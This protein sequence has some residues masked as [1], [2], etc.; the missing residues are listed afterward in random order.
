[1]GEIIYRL[2]KVKYNNKVMQNI[3]GMAQLL[4]T[5]CVPATQHSNLT[6][7]SPTLDSTKI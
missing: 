6:N 4:K 2:S 3:R 7:G 1:M 5:D